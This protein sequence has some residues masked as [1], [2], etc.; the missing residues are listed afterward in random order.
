ME[1]EKQVMKKCEERLWEGGGERRKTSVG[2]GKKRWS[3][4]NKC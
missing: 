2:G 4:K 1:Q 3:K